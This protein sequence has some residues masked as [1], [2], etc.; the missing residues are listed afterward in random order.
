MIIASTKLFKTTL[1]AADV[2]E[3]LFI[4][5]ADENVTYVELFVDVTAAIENL[6]S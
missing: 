4:F 2:V 6:T 3:V 5:A 1:P